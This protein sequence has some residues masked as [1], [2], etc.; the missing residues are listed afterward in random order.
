MIRLYL[1][2]VFLVGGFVNNLEML[3]YYFEIYFLYEEYNE[4]IVEMI[5]CYDLN[6]CIINW[7]S[8]YIVYLKEVEK[9]VNFLQLIGVIILMFEFENIWIV[10][11]M[12]NLV[13]W[14]VNCENV[15]M[16]KV[17]NVV[18][19]QV[20]NIMLIEVM[21]GLSSFFEKLCVI[22]EIRLVY[23]E[24][25]L[26]ELGMLVFGGLIL[27]LGVNYWFCKLNVYVD[28]LWQGKVI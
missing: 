18:N 1:W 4:M 23:Q 11:D 13:N 15:N 6:V 8:G 7:C 25:S 19:C 12:C 17:V 28:E 20:E 16:D 3:C 22:V 21:V 14:L 5:N 24:V 2:G 10:C 27:K 9:I 26:K